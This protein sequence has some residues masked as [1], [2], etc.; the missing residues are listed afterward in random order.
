MIKME[1][2]MAT[3]QEPV[4][5]L[6]LLVSNKN[7]EIKYLIYEVVGLGG[8]R[9]EGG[10]WVPNLEETD[11]QFDDMR[12]FNIDINKSSDLLT[13]WD[14]GEEL[15]EEDINQYLLPEETE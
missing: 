3:N 6:E 5:M 15:S 14:S 10:K 2:I 13:K 11:D 1:R 8:F 4:E 7:S 9:R 12:V